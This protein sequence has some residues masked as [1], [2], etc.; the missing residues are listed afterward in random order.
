MKRTPSDA[1][2]KAVLDAVFAPLKTR[3][4]RIENARDN[5]LAGILIGVVAALLG[6]A[7]M[8]CKSTTAS[9]DARTG[10]WRVSD[11]RLLL[12]TEAEVTASVETNGAK[13]ITIKAKSDPQTE[14]FKAI[15]EGAASGAARAVRQ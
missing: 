10:N 5:F 11:R 7:L 13:Q 15:A 6:M 2:K 8:G 9:Y 3:E 4:E 12:R 1:E 14:A